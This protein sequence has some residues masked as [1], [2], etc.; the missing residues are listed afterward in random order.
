V[1]GSQASERKWAIARALRT[2]KREMPPKEKK[3]SREGKGKKEEGAAPGID[4]A[5]K[6][7]K[8]GKGETFSQ[9]SISTT[10]Y[11]DDHGRTENPLEQ[12][13]S[14]KSKTLRKRGEKKK[15]RTLT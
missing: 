5:S 9:R 4:G 6:R 12:C 2:E 7:G 8:K 11:R 3:R 1:R 13:V 14:K 15:T 10:C